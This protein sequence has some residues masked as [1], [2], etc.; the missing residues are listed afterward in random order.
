MRELEL[1]MTNSAA[2]GLSETL[3]S[4]PGGGFGK[5]ALN[6]D[7]GRLDVVRNRNSLQSN[8]LP[9]TGIEPAPP[10]ED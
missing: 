3:I 10:C 5:L 1:R 6:R 2:P 8:E 4:R 7:I 9:R